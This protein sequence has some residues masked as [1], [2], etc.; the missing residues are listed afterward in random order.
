VE[1][2]IEGLVEAVVL[3][4]VLPVRDPGH[5]DEVPRGGDRQELGQALDD[6]EDERLAVRK[7]SRVVPHSEHREHD[8]ETER[9]RCDAEHDRAAHGADPTCMRRL[10][11]REKNGR[12][13]RQ[14]GE[15]VA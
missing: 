15:R 5:E 14:S 8:R 1:R 11:C 10:A 12:K 9:R 4:E 2:D 3:L 13:L 6:P 7:R